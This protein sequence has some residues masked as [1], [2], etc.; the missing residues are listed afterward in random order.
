VVVVGFIA[1]ILT[2]AALLHLP[3]ATDGV[4]HSF[5][6]RLFTATSAGTVTGLQVVDT[7]TGW[8]HFGQAVIMVLAQIGGFGLMAFSSV[9][10]VALAG[11][12][13]LRHRLATQAEVNLA[14]GADF[15]AVILGVFRWSMGIEATVAVALFGGFVIIHGEP[16][17]RAAWL[18]LFHAVTSFNNAGFA[19]FS[20]NLAG[21]VDDP[22]TSGVI[23]TSIVLGG[24]GFPVLMELRRLYRRPRRWSLHT[25]IT[26]VATALLIAGGALAVLVI[27]WSNPNTLGPMGIDRQGDRRSLPGHHPPHRRV[28]HD[29][30]RR[31][32]RVVDRG[33]HRVD[34]H[35]RGQC[36][37]RKRHQGDHLRRAGVGDLGRTARRPRGRLVSAA[38]PRVRP[39]PGDHR[40]A[41]R[42][43]AGHRLYD[44]AGDLR[45]HSPGRRPVRGHQR[46][47]HRRVDHRD[48]PTLSAGSHVVLIVM[49]FVGRVGPATLGAALVLR[50]HTRRYRYPEERPLIG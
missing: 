10:A 19:L 29:R 5:L 35:R 25:K 22:W 13:E 24:I 30:L 17:G 32:A 15:K 27:E 48:H 34:V 8:T 42:G 46:V 23:A 12:L 20:D 2:G 1:V 50:E 36:L 49:M 21:F 45:P 44:G 28:Q 37:H 18:G 3:I 39:A 41:Q 40:G 33:H 47:R 9:V 4:E 16:L 26:L 14:G 11:K 31:H 43:G 7:A 38:H 6:D